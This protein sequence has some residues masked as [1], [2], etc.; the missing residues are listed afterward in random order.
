MKT[1]NVGITYNFIQYYLPT[2][3]HKQE[4]S[5]EM[6]TTADIKFLE[7]DDSEFPV[8]MKVTKNQSVYEGAKEAEDFNG[9]DSEYKPFTEDLRY[10]NGKLYKAL[11]YNYGAAVSTEFLSAENIIN[12]IK[13]CYGKERCYVSSCTDFPY[14]EGKS[15]ILG[16]E[17]QAAAE[18]IQKNADR[19]ILCDGKAWEE[20]GEPVYHIQTFGLGNNHGGTGLFIEYLRDPENNNNEYYFNAN[21]RTK[22]LEEADNTAKRRGDTEDLGT[23]ADCCNIEVLLPEA[24]KYDRNRARNRRIMQEEENAGETITIG[25]IMAKFAELDPSTK[26]F[27][28]KDRWSDIEKI[29]SISRNAL[30]SLILTAN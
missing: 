1:L 19:Y 12:G 21:E 15:I 13:S 18:K 10:Y 7:L 26:V 9:K 30:G 2:K 6:T 22:A 3:R 28:K 20:C 24:V 5:R 11:R 29:E 4:R 25:D 14:E 23:F 8:A 27:L 16:D 17:K